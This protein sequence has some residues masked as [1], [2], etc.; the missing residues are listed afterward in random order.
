MSS[1]Q[2]KENSFIGIRYVHSQNTKIKIFA[3]VVEM[4]ILLKI[5]SKNSR[6]IV[7]HMI[8]DE[9]YIG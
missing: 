5:P 7:L 4:K 2:F 9:C 3:L 6:V 8:K 1:L